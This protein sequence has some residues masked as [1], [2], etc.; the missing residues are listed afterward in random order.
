VFYWDQPIL[1]GWVG[2]V[3]WV[4]LCSIEE[5]PFLVGLVDQPFQPASNRVEM[6][7]NAFV[8]LRCVI[9]AHITTIPRGYRVSTKNGWKSV[10]LRRV[11]RINPNRLHG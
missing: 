11:N 10:L 2:W 8:R 5:K 1:V 3:G 9:V 4:F 6:V 7:E